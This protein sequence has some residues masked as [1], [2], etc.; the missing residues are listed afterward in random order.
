MEDKARKEEE[1]LKDSGRESHSSAESFESRLGRLEV[2]KNSALL[3][4]TIIAERRGGKRRRGLEV[5]GVEK[6]LPYGLEVGCLHEFYSAQ[7]GGCTSVVMCWLGELTRLGKWVYWGD[8]VGALDIASL[9][10]FE[11]DTSHFIWVRGLGIKGKI[12]SCFKAVEIAILSNRFEVVV[13][14]LLGQRRGY[15]KDAWWF[16]L[17]RQIEKSMVS[18]WVLVEGPMIPC[19]AYRFRCSRVEW[20]K[21]KFECVVE[22]SQEECLSKKFLI[23]YSYS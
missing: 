22:R 1:F 11:V 7:K 13:L 6:A 20:P 5:L 15:I 8:T 9:N 18:L 12:E 17:M 21:K 10:G 23:D 14:D 16:R 3:R 2:L 4:P 19:A